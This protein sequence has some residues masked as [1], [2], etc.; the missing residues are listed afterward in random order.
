MNIFGI[1]LLIA[2][3][4]RIRK[5]VASNAEVGFPLFEFCQNEFTRK[6]LLMR[7]RFCNL[8]REAECSG[9]ADATVSYSTDY[10]T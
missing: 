4:G 7:V 10:M 1:L 5:N 6:S 3:D 2:V 9:E 8:I